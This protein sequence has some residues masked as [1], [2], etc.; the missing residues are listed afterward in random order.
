VQS[1]Q[2]HSHGHQQRP[3]QQQ[4]SA[5]NHHLSYDDVLARLNAYEQQPQ[6]YHQE[7][8]HP[9]PRGQGRYRQ[10]QQDPYPNTQTQEGYYQHYYQYD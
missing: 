1:E 9:N 6:Q 5:N 4:G 8:P 3:L 7:P 2:Q 10:P